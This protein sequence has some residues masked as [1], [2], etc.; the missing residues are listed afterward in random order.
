MEREIRKLLT[1]CVLI[2]CGV[3]LNAQL[4][5]HGLNFNGGSGWVNVKTDTYSERDKGFGYKAGA[6][7]GY[8]LRFKELVPKYFHYDIDVNIGSK[9]LHPALKP[10]EYGKTK[11][12]HDFFTSICGTANYSIMKNLS[13][14][15]GVEPTYYYKKEVFRV[16]YRERNSHFDIPL[17]AKVAYKFKAVEVSIYGKNGLINV[18]GSKSYQHFNYKYRDIQMSLFIP[19]KTK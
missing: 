7:V 5:E 11:A 13:I 12:D 10:G 4:S 8:R 15:L 3:S 9:L 1:T 2:I 17:I 19:L 18:L 6:S 14:G 16:H